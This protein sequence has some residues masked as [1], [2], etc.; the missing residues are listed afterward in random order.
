[1]PLLKAK[2]ALNELPAGGLLRVLATDPGSERDFD[3]FSRQSGHVL[4]ES[5]RDDDVF[6]YLLKKKDP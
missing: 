2:K 4:L 6:I 5:T 3:T 1:M